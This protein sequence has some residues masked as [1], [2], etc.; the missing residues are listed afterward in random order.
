MARLS[1]SPFLQLFGC[2]FDRLTQKLALETCEHSK[3]N[4]RAAFLDMPTI[5]G[6]TCTKL[7]TMFKEQL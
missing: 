4:M 3:C 1:S 7:N 6:L 2:L 5:F